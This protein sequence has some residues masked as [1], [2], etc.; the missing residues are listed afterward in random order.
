MPNGVPMF[1]AFRMTGLTV[2]VFPFMYP[3]CRAKVYSGGR[4]AYAC[5][6]DLDVSLHAVYR[7]LV[8]KEIASHLRADGLTG[9]ALSVRHRMQL[10]RFAQLLRPTPYATNRYLSLLLFV[11]YRMSDAFEAHRSALGAAGQQAEP[12]LAALRRRRPHRS[13]PAIRPGVRP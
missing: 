9:Q 11:R 1:P 2:F 7:A 13:A 8:G 5:C 12:L 4:I 3:Y 10:R 6:R